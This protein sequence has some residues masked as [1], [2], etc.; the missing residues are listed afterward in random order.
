ME[1]PAK[2]YSVGEHLTS[3]YQGE[4]GV[5]KEVDW[6]V[7]FGQWTYK[8]ERTEVSR[9][10]NRPVGTEVWVCQSDLARKG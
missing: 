2:K 4:T 7:T 6:S 5:V 10:D 3:K 9:Y 8:L 1:R